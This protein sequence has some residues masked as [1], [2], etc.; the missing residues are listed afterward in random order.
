MCTIITYLYPIIGTIW[1]KNY[2]PHRFELWNAE[3]PAR[4][5]YFIWSNYNFFFSCAF[6]WPQKL[7]NWNP[8][9]QNQWLFHTFY[10]VCFPS[11]AQDM[12]RQWPH[13]NIHTYIFDQKLHRLKLLW[14][15]I[16]C[17]SH[18]VV[19]LMK[20]RKIPKLKSKLTA[21]QRKQKRN[22]KPI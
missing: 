16:V 10:V 17:R 6:S 21:I 20:Y 11:Y 13:T 8:K 7:L 4:F 15:F 14:L 18:S 1:I 9:P 3:Y 12:L 22:E 2:Q 5:A 19:Y